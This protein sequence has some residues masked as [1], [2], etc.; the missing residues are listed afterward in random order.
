MGRVDQGVAGGAE[1]SFVVLFRI[2]CS[3]SS[4]PPSSDSCSD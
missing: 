3:S 1:Y 2:S 4:L